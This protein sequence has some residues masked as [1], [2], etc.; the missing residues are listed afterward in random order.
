MQFRQGDV[1][2]ERVEDGELPDGA[3]ELAR[4]N[5]RV[6]LAYGEVTG[7]A[8]AIAERTATLFSKPDNQDRWLVI[9]WADGVPEGSAATIRHEEHAPISLAPGLY[10]ITHQR[11]YAP[12]EIRRVAD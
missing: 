10:R 12:G 3:V 7:H 8:H 5:G 1:F 9:G 6:V 2:V 11:E 4:D